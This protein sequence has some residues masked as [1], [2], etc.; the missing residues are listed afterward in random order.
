ML[1]SVYVNESFVDFL[2]AP[3]LVL[4]EMASPP[5][6]WTRMTNIYI[7]PVHMT[8]LCAN[9]DLIIPMVT[10]GMMCFYV[11][12]RALNSMSR[13]LWRNEILLAFPSHKRLHHWMLTIIGLSY[14]ATVWA[15]I[16]FWVFSRGYLHLF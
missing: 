5:G 14:K 16:I 8:F 2:S 10:L 9:V 7:S 3:S 6:N 1:S 11:F 13:S 15:Y 12:M 4:S